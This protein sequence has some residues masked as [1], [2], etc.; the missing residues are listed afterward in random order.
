LGAR[1]TW[2][3]CRCSFWAKP[4]NRGT[5]FVL[6]L[7][8]E[9]Y[10]P[11]IMQFGS[12]IGEFAAIGAA[13]CWVFSSL[14]FAGAARRIGPSAVNLLRIILACGLVLLVHRV[15]VGAW[16]PAVDRVGAAYLAVSGLI[17]FAIGD[18]FLFHAFV[19]VGSRLTT[20][21]MT[22]T[23]PVTAVLALALLREPLDLVSMLGMAMTLAGIA[24]VAMERPDPPAS[25]DPPDPDSPGQDSPN[26]DSPNSKAHRTHPHRVR[27]LVFGSIAAVCQACGLILSKIGI[28][29]S[30][31]PVEQFVDTWSASLVRLT[32]GAISICILA[33]LRRA[34][35]SA[36]ARGEIPGASGSVVDIPPHP[37]PSHVPRAILL[38]TIGTVLGPVVGV[39]CSLMAIDRAPAAIAST[40]MAMTPVLILPFAAI[41]E[42]ERI[43]WRAVAGAIVAV[44]GVAVLT[45]LT[46]LL[47]HH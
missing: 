7:C 36:T 17:G 41:F 42:R 46:S 14:T 15:T 22:L 6:F 12:H 10:Y 25:P 21:L 27:G 26:Q 35:E 32:A 16:L 43:T 40:L 8:L 19:D 30:R 31:L 18:Q 37:K 38:L 39:W 23:P 3:I 5:P 24:W 11:A 2:G 13:T 33:A 9:Q 44:A 20:L 34:G 1:G 28:G 29:H 47:G 45:G 4:E